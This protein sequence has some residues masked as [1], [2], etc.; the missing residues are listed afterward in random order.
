MRRVIAAVKAA[1]I[2]AADIRT[3]EVGL[4]RQR[5][6]THHGKHR[7]VVYRA[8]N[9]IGVTVRHIGTSGKVI[10]AAVNAGATGVSGIE[11]S[12]SK[13]DDLRRQ[14]LGDA[15]DEARA[16]AETLAEHAGATLGAA[17]QIT[18]GVDTFNGG[19]QQNATS[20]STGTPIEPG[21]TKI[22]AEVTV[23]FALE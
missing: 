6:K 2:P 11:L 8:V 16:K 18:E 14:A 23:T 7:R 10:D 1:G 13:V 3:Q 21:T 22:H 4:S 17:Q 5:I 20:G 12:S 19:N 15:F 9:G